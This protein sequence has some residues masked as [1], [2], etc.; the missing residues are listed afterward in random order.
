VAA[1]IGVRDIHTIIT[2]LISL[3]LLYLTELQTG[4]CCAPL[5]VQYI[6]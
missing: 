1:G 5:N 3:R 4:S 6:L 2:Q